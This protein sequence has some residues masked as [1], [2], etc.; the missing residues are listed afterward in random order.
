LL[1]IRAWHRS[2]G[3]G[4]KRRRVI[5]PDSA[6]GTNPAS[7]NLVGYEMVTIP[8]DVH[9]TVSL[10]QLEKALDDRTA[11]V[12]LT[13]PNTLGLF[14]P[15]ILEVTRR[16]HEAGAQVY[17]DGA[18]LNALV[19]LVKPASL[20]FDVMHINVHKTFSTPHGGGGP[21]G[22]TGGGRP[23]LE[24]FLPAAGRGRGAGRRALDWDR[25]HSVGRVHSLFN[26]NFG[27]P[28]AGA[29]LHPDPRPGRALRGQPDRDPE[30]ETG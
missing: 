27:N 10:A 29:H 30:R 22:G 24:P 5:V 11:A 28:G 19:G 26:G 8:S 20:G 25:P 15:E 2:R 6:H 12:M 23:H 21:G 1:L 7:V 9:A 4:E 17:L 18:N 3:E 16:A 13:V 14:E